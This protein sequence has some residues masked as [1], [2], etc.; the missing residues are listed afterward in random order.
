MQNEVIAKI[1]SLL[2]ISEPQSN[3]ETLKVELREIECSIKEINLNIKELKSSMNDDKYFDASAEI[4]DKNIEISL[5]KKIKSIKKSLEELENQIEKQSILE[6][7]QH[8]KIEKIKK[9]IVKQNS[10]IE[11]LKEK[12][13]SNFDFDKENFKTLLKENEQKLK[14]NEK[15]LTKLTKD[16]E[17]IQGKL[18]VLSFSKKELK[19]KIDDETEK[20]LDVKANLL[21]KRGYVNNDLKKE[22]QETLELLEKKLKDLEGSKNRILENPLMIAEEAKNY[23]LDD[24]KTGCLKKVKELKDLISK[25]PYMSI[26]GVN[27]S[28]NLKIE[29]ENAEAKRD[30][31]SSMINSKNYES[32]DTTLIKDRLTFI[33]DKKINIEKDINELSEKIKSTDTVELEDLNNRIN[34][35]E[36]EV[37]VIEDKINEFNSNFENEELTLSKKSSLQAALDKKRDELTNINKLLEC[38]KN[39]RKDLITKSFDIE[40]NYINK[41]KEDINVIDKEIKELEKILMTSSKSKNT[42]EIEN[43]K[44]KLKELNDNIK[45][46]K[47]RQN[48]K[49]SPEEIY[50]EIELSLG[51]EMDSF[52]NDAVTSEIVETPAN[53]NDLEQDNVIEQAEE[54]ENDKIDKTVIE[55]SPI[56]SNE[57]DQIDNEVT[58]DSLPVIDDEELNL[59]VTD[60]NEKEDK[61]KVINVESLE[62]NSEDIEPTNNEFLIGDYIS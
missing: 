40:K 34:Y 48:L 22:D 19:T 27:S 15:E 21:N 60:V 41:L 1:D 51:T 39:D 35:C 61:L 9:E 31:F 47:K 5:A 62:E 32:V 38:Y 45:A 36:N 30:E 56:N 49:K 55:D 53:I 20:L 44:N 2:K 54:R 42:I 17:K 58:I 29:L 4:V 46:I 59:E 43:D 26:N 24:D 6:Q 12:I 33:Q 16:Y 28:E 50:D 3:I 52:E 57:L 37:K 25:I 11:I 23:L 8:D 14:S 7:N 10:F 13:A 18:E